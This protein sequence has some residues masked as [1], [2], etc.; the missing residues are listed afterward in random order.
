MKDVIIPLLLEVRDL[1]N[2]SSSDSDEEEVAML[3]NIVNKRRKIARVENYV[4]IIVPALTIEDFKA[5]F[6][7]QLCK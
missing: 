5:H 4:E 7:Y 2:A 6:R 1:I 3:Q